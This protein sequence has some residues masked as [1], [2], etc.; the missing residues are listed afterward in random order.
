MP[1]ADGDIAE[2]VPGVTELAEL[3]QSLISFPWTPAVFN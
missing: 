1:G 2:G 3:D